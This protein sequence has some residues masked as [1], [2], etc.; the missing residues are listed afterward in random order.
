LTGKFV[1]HGEMP[2]RV[3][4]T[5]VMVSAALLVSV[6]AQT[7]VPPAA[8]GKVRL[9]IQGDDMGVGH[10][11]NVATIEAHT[12]GVLKSANVI[13]TGSW[14]PEAAR[15]LN[16]HPEIDAGVHL[17]LTSEWENVKWRPLTT[18][19]SLVDAHGYFFPTVVPRPGAPAGTSMREA[20]LDLGEIER[21]LRAQIVL[22]KALIPH[23]TYTW[24]HMGFGSV[25]PDVRAIVR[26][27]TKEHGL[28]TPGP[29]NGVS[30][31]RRV[32]DNTDSGAVRARKL[33]AALQALTPGTWLMVEHA[34][35]DTPEM[36]AFGH[37]GYEHVAVD[38]QAVLDAWTSAEVR[39]AI[40]A[41]GIE[42]TSLR[43]ALK[44]IPR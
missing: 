33:A 35:T 37:A 17:A 39:A 30:F 5:S 38:R 23:L 40:D 10:G 4:M 26:R 18:A 41:R 16:A 1:D 19:P 24:E 21:E 36:R 27:L 32:W 13:I 6:A 15:L 11:I 9:I 29:D 20:R 2:M 43:E 22:A 28:V 25:S 7:P 8:D 12:R 3:A 42:L 34:A 44:N 31:L 14:V